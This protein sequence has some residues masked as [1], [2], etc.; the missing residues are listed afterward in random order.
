MSTNWRFGP[1][2]FFGEDLKRRSL[3]WSILGLGM[4]I[5]IGLIAAWTLRQVSISD[6]WV[7]HTREVISN[8]T[9]LRSYLE[10]AEDAQR[11]YIL[12]G[13]ETYLEPYQDAVSRI[14]DTLATLRRLTSDNSQQQ[15][16]FRE[17]QPL[18]DERIAGMAATVSLRQQSGFEAAQKIVVGGQGKDVMDRIRRVEGDT[19][20]DEYRLLQQ[21]SEIRQSRLRQGFAA[22]LA[23]A[24]V[25]L[26][27]LVAFPLDVRRAVG[28]RDAARRRQQESETT[29]QALFE[30]A[31][32]GIFIVDRQG[33]IRMANPATES[34]FGFRVEEML[35]QPVEMLIPESLHAQ[36]IGHRDHYFARP[37]TRPMGLGLDLQARRKDGSE[38]FVEISLSYIQTQQDTLAV[39][40]VT[41]VSK[42]RA[43]AQA[44]RRQGEELRG[45]A[46]RLMTAQD[47]ERRRIARDLHDDLS[48][49]L[50]YLAIDLGKLASSPT[51]QDL[52]GFLRSLQQRAAEA[53][54]NVRQISHR[55]HPSILDDI[56]LAAALE[57]YCEEF[58]EAYGI[59]AHFDSR[60]V[61]DAL[62]KDIANSLYHI[63]QECLRNVAKH[64][65]SDTVFVTLEGVGPILRLTVKDAGIG[66]NTRQ[67]PPGA[68]IGIVGMKERAHLVNGRVAIKSQSGEGTEVRVEIPLVAAT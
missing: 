32:Q 34:M 39:A 43:D 31:A 30:V 46:A 11:G 55:L 20:Q 23:A 38:F 13:Q 5:L 8:T 62:P 65:Q 44:I 4:L 66:L 53:A 61:P 37:Q 3:L 21:R 28:Q 6:M 51:P 12:T 42:R 33:R 18:I 17:L 67:L 49:Q 27:A 45:L 1:Q 54:E 26:L 7:D 68:G 9:D 40:F 64:S 15:Q 56:G 10:R 58:E 52:P 57:Q 2:P 48:Q 47:D 36:H 35:G 59:A 19:E 29:A 41:D 63:A 24:L 22:T 60:D 50:A 25:A 14:P 16:R